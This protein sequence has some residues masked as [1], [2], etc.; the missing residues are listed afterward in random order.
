MNRLHGLAA[1]P[2]AFDNRNLRGS[3]VNMDP[4]L[5]QDALVFKRQLVGHEMMHV[6][7]LCSLEHADV[8]EAA[9]IGKHVPGLADFGNAAVH[10]DVLCGRQRN[11]GMQVDAV[12][13]GESLGGIEGIQERA[14]FLHDRLR[15]LG[16]VF[17]D[18]ASQ[19]EDVDI[20]IQ[21]VRKRAD[22]VRQDGQ[23]PELSEKLCQ[24]AAQESRTEDDDVAVLDFFAGL[25][26]NGVEDG[27]FAQ[28]NGRLEHQ[29]FGQDRAAVDPFG[30]AF[31]FQNGEVMADGDFAYAVSAA[32]FID[33]YLLVLVELQPDF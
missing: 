28:E 25:S 15:Q 17:A 11:A 18:F 26:R 4:V 6:G 24:I 30:T 21:K 32:Q 13:F 20:Q 22:V 1:G 3:N 9:V 2:S 33:G 29:V 23:I 12:S 19:H 7:Q 10:V 5:L 27:I 14:L 31:L 16:A 8:A